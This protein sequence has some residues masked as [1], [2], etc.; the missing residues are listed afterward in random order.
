[1]CEDAVVVK[2][3]VNKGDCEVQ[4]RDKIFGKM[5]ERVDVPDHG[6]RRHDRMK[7]LMLHPLRALTITIKTASASRI[8]A[9][10][11]QAKQCSASR[12]LASQSAQAS[13][14]VLNARDRES[15]WILKHPRFMIA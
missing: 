3:I 1:M 15:S 7:L 6:Q 12:V 9:V 11:Q 14:N 10:S 13:Q 5:E 4:A 2:I 8:C